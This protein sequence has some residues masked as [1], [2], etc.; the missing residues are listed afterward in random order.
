MIQILILIHGLSSA[1]C[2]S[3]KIQRVRLIGFIIGLIGQPLWIYQTYIS[4]QWGMAIVSSI[5]IFINIRGILNNKKDGR[6]K[7]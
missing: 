6:I 1:I 7:I 5:Y 3:S 2:I 4:N